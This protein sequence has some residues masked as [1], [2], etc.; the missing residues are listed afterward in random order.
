MRHDILVRETKVIEII[1]DGLEILIIDL[2][3]EKYINIGKVLTINSAIIQ[4]EGLN[5]AS[6][7]MVNLHSKKLDKLGI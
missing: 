7:I 3:N 4:I 1:D 5:L 6:E 2:I